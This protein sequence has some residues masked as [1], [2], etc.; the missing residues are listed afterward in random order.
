MYALTSGQIKVHWVMIYGRHVYLK[1][2]DEK[3]Y[4]DTFKVDA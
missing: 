3:I 1:K 2:N 4:K